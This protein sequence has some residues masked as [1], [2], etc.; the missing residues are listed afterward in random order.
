MKKLTT[1][2]LL[3]ILLFTVTVTFVGCGDKDFSDFEKRIGELENNYNGLNN[4]YNDLN[5]NSPDVYPVAFL[6]KQN[7]RGSNWLYAKKLWISRISR[8]GARPTLFAPRVA[9]FAVVQ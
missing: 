5:N 4:N 9:R 6:S 8:P 1:F 2:I 7:A 3:I